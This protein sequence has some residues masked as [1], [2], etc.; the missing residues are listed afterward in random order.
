[1]QKV[2]AKIHLGNIRRNAERFREATGTP[3]CAVVKAN[4]YGHGAEEVTN[5]LSGVASS[6]AVSILDE[7]LQIRT[8]ACGKEI[9]VLTPPITARDV[10]CGA[11][12]GFSL[13]VGDLV[14]AKLI[15]GVAGLQKIPV[16]VHVKVNTGMNRYGMDLSALGKVCKRLQE[17]PCVRV[18]GIYSH[19]YGSQRATAEKQRAE[20]EKA[21][22]VCRRYFPRVKAHLSATYG[23]LLGK[24]FAFDG[25]RIG[26]G[27]YGYLPNGLTEQDITLPALEKGMTVYATAATSRRYRDGGA[28]YG[29]NPFAE[30]KPPQTLTV[31]RYGYADGFLR[32]RRNGA[33]GEETQ[34]NN[35][36]MDACIRSGKIARGKQFAVMTDAAAVARATGTIPYEVLCA[37][38]RRAE[39]IYDNE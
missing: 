5:A 27:L 29:E 39:M 1:M 9:L 21:V 13:T 12:N 26:L 25:V 36:C 38:T 11:W 16:N 22:A 18:V 4:A 31:C 35:L 3:L 32:Q 10:L 23:G 19:L 17:N 34:V 24:A 6:F 33:L 15:D 14:T 8:A 2:L 30:G 20:F 28:G 7:G 37:A